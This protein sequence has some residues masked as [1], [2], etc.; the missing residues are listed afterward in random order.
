MV[1]STAVL[2]RNTLNRETGTVNRNEN[3]LKSQLVGGRPVGYLQ[4][5]DELNLGLP[6]TNP[7]SGQS[8]TRTR[9]R[10]ITSPTR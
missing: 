2:I 4:D 7:S 1:L 10:W 5:V 6:N 3:L 8:G 9:D